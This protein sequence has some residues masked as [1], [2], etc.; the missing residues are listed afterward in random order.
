FPKSFMPR[1]YFIVVLSLFIFQCSKYP[2]AEKAK[3]QGE[4]EHI[5]I[6]DT[7]PKHIQEIEN[8]TVFPGDSEPRF[9]IDLIP[10]QTFGKT[11][12]SYLTNILAIVVDDQGRV[13]ILDTKSDYSN[14]IN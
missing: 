11:G 2:S 13:I 7:I 14:V 4:S 1:F 10:V 3:N 5:S 6:L 12:E 8:L 9:S